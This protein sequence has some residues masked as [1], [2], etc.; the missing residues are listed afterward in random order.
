MLNEKLT[1]VQ[2]EN[3]VLKQKYRELETH[4]DGVPN[5]D[6]NNDVD[7]A[8][9]KKAG[10]KSPKVHVMNICLFILLFVYV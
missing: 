5:S 10:P 7:P 3:E 2:E 8:K 6:N 4:T 9:P 1:Q